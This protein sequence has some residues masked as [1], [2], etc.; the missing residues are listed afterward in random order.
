MNSYVDISV[1]IE[2][3]L[4]SIIV[5]NFGCGI[6]GN[7]TT[8]IVRVYFGSLSFS[9]G[10][11]PVIELLNVRNPQSTGPTSTFAVI[12]YNS[13]GQIVEYTNVT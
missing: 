1:P 2:L 12:I 13:Q 3:S 11:L 6:V 4:P 9:I 10:Q 5:C 7:S 8:T